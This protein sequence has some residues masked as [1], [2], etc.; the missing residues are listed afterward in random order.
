MVNN[1]PVKLDVP[2]T[3]VDGRTYVPLRFISESLDASVQWN[4]DAKV[5]EIASGNRK[6]FISATPNLYYRLGVLVTDEVLVNKNSEALLSVNLTSA[7]YDL[8]K[9]KLILASDSIIG[10][11]KNVTTDYSKYGYNYDLMYLDVLY[12]GT[13]LE[14]IEHY[15]NNNGGTIKNPDYQKDINSIS[16][17][18]A[19]KK[20][21]NE[22]NKEIEKA[23]KTL[24]NEL[25]A[26]NNVPLKIESVEVDSNSIGTPE[27]T[28]Y[29]K[30]LSPKTIIAYELSFQCYD[31]YD[32]PVKRFLNNSNLFNG[33]SQ[34]DNILS[35]QQDSATWT[36]TLYDLTTNVKNVKIVSVRFSDG[37][38][39]RR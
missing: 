4:S 30:N 18:E 21:V 25:K 24:A 22:Y 5:A 6:I 14:S 29:I 16:S 32:R 38:T 31:S 3:V 33:I 35:G 26:N 7:W 28:L 20:K 34:N 8:S 13:V 10:V 2:A 27:V 11:G 36:L 12:L 19:I 1:T 9:N 39:W 37:T 17:P 15:S 23:K